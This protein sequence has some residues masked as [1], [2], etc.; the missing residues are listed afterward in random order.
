MRL[1]VYLPQVLAEN[2]LVALESSSRLEPQLPPLELR[3][4]RRYGAARV[5]LFEKS[6]A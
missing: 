4:S 2:G 3:T 6:R 5:T 1:A